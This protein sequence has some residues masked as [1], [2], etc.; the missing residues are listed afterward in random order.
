MLRVGLTGGIGCGK[1]AVS[2]QFS[3]LGVPVIDADRISHQLTAPGQPLLQ[4]IADT[5]G[6]GFVSAEGVLDR[7]ALRAHVFS[8]P[9]ARARLEAILHPAIRR[10]MREQLAAL[11]ADYAVLVIPL[12]LE[13]GQ[14]DLVDRILV[15]DCP[16]S[17]QRQRVLARDRIPAEQLTQILAAQLPREQRL[18]AADDIIV[19]DGSPEDL[20][21]AVAAL[22]RQYRRLAK[23]GGFTH[24]SG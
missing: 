3:L 12:L 23:Q 13:S 6:G 24:P 14:Q 17:L 10:A 7:A 15:V 16:P 9:E 8:H 5:L 22:D 18:A 11:D 21:R 20:A 1:S 4:T 2:E 19:N